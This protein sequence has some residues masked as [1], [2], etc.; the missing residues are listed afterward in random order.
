MRIERL[1]IGSVNEDLTASGD[2]TQ[3]RLTRHSF[4]AAGCGVM[5]V[6]RESRLYTG[7]CRTWIYSWDHCKSPLQYKGGQQSGSAA[8]SGAMGQ[9]QARDGAKGT[10]RIA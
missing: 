8:G 2:R 10:W 3:A 1:D 5:G 6:Y 9:G 4:W 7:R